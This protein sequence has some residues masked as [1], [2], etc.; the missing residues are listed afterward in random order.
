MRYGK[1]SQKLENEKKKEMDRLRNKN[2]S[3]SELRYVYQ[4]YKLQGVIR[5]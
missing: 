5:F 4:P 1:Q 2:R 3:P